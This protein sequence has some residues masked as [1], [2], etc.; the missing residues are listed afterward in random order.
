M[1]RRSVILVAALIA[2]CASQP[3]ISPLSRPVVAN[4]QGPSVSAQSLAGIVDAEEFGGLPKGDLDNFHAVDK[5]VFRGA[6]PTDKGLAMLK[7][8]GI[9]T[10]INLED[11]K[12]A[13]SHE[14]EVASDL[15]IDVYT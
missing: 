10:I 2:G 9:R 6:R 7:A 5:R 12:A 11:T 13:V 15:G 14:Q 3:M 4:A 1:Q 8:Q